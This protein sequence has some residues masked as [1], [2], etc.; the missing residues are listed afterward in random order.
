MLNPGNKIA[1]TY[2]IKGGLNEV[3]AITVQKNDS[4]DPLI[5]APVFLLAPIKTTGKQATEGTGILVAAGCADFFPVL[6]GG[7]QQ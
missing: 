5:L 1:V 3:V 2:K 7:G 4:F 6:A